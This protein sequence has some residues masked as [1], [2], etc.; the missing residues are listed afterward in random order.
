MRERAVVLIIAA[1]WC[2]AV[3]LGSG[4]GD[5]DWGKDWD[6]AMRDANAAW[7]AGDLEGAEGLFGES[8]ELARDHGSG[9]LRQA[10]SADDLAFFYMAAGEY[11]SAVPL[12]LEAI[13]LLERLLGPR[14]P[15]VATSLHNLGVTYLR[16]DRYDLAEPVLVRA[17]DVWEASLGPEHPETAKTLQAYANLLYRTGRI[18]AAE[19]V[20]ARIRSISGTPDSRK[21]GH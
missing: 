9:T 7:R 10:R 19:T 12:Y 1:G 2:V 8:L 5:H 4:G 18:D 14:Q 13:P 17:I 21:A 16:L 11:E 20:E 15:R 3:T 6:E